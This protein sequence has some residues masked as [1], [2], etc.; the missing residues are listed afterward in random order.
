M[1]VIPSRRIVAHA[2]VCAA[3]IGCSVPAYATNGFFLIGYGNKARAMGGASVA[4][5]HDSL[6]I[7]ANPAT[8]SALKMDTMR[9]DLS[10]EIFVPRRAS[11]HNA[12]LLGGVYDEKSGA[13]VFLIPAMGGAYKFNRRMTI[14][15][16]AVGAGSNTRFDQSLAVCEDGDPNTTGSRFYNYECNSGPTAGVNLL[17]MQMLP[18]IAYKL[19]KNHSVGASLALAVSSF[20]AYGLQ[21]MGAPGSP[22]NFTSDRDNLSNRGNDFAYGAGVRFG[23]LSN[24]FD[25]RVSVGANY[26]SRVYMTKFDKYRGLFAEQGSFDIPEHFALGLSLR[27]IESLTLAFDVQRYMFS[28]VRSVGNPGP[29]P[30]NPSSFFPED[31]GCT[32]PGTEPADNTC[33]LGKDDGMGFGWQ[34]QFVYKAGVQFEYNPKWTLRAGYNYGKA[35]IPEDQIAF[36]LLAPATVEHHATAGFSYRQSPN[37]E[38][39]MSYMIA[40]KN[41]I[42]GKTSF[43]PEGINNIDDLDKP[44][45]ATSM[46]QHSLGLTFSY[47]M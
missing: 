39:S 15:M 16:A 8:M 19:T 26:A 29:D 11:S 6:S 18:S 46:Y 32:N 43:Y 12:D 24:F 44:N 13:N 45:A 1:K 25:N 20:R 30:A 41:T 36:N 7:A 17:Q 33:A 28:D 4:M 27:P 22:L 37:I 23:W 38:W 2:L 42:K 5:A 40:F 31:F 35:P 10:G 34:N 21:S 9:I 14:G 3:A 47:L